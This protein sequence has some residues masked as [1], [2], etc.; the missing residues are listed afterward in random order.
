MSSEW[1]TCTLGSLIKHKK[2]LAFK[3]K[4]YQD[5]GVPVI[6]V[7]NF[8]DNTVSK[9]DLKFVPES[10]AAESKDVELTPCDIVVATVGSWPNN[11]AS[12]VGRAISIPSWAKGALMNQNAVILRAKS[13]DIHDQRFIYYQTRTEAFSHHVVS[14]A[15]G[16]ANQASITLDVIFSFPVFWPEFSIRKEIAHFLNALDDRIA[17]LRETNATL[18]AIAQAL[19]KSWFVD[20]DPVH[21]NAGTQAPSLP[22]EIQALFPSRLVE[23]PQGLIPEGWAVRQLGEVSSYLSRGISPKY[24]DECGVCVINQKCIRDF[25]ID[26]AKAR[27]HDPSQRKIDGRELVFGDVLVNSTGVGT[28]GRVAQVLELKET[29]IVDSHVTVVRAETG[30]GWIYL[31]QALMRKQPEIEAMGEGTTGQT[32]LARSKLGLLPIICPTQAILKQFDSIILPL[33][34][35]T[36]VNQSKIK[37]LASLRDTLLPRL[38]SGQLRSPEAEVELSEVLA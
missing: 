2:G 7:S 18:E 24:V 23:S 16:S 8:S 31:G 25:A 1:Q 34:Q 3:S 12:V 6:R 5:S 22:A 13:G 38:I 19:F 35:S 14:K 17:L 33:K 21:A 29:T 36:A 10:V 28:L 15:Q 4:D 37:M 20:F 30:L 9:N 27:R 11:P 26:L 32:E